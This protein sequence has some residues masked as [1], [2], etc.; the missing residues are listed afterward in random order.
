MSDADTTIQ[1]KKKRGRPPKE[2]VANPNGVIKRH[3]IAYAITT[4]ELIARISQEP[5]IKDLA[6][7]A[8]K[9]LD[10]ASK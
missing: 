3:T 2:A 5:E 10:A 9:E 4:L 1:P 6:K 8:A 7:N